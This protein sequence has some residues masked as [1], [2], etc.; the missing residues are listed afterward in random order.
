MPIFLPSSFAA[1]LR[2]PHGDSGFR[3]R[4]SS[5]QSILSATATGFA[6]T[7]IMSP[8]PMRLH[9]EPDPIFRTIAFTAG[10]G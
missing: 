9:G 4:R 8:R 3:F 7:S 6:S 5:K 10:P 2:L 1:A